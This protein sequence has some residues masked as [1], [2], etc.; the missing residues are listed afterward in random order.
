MKLPLL[1]IAAATTISILQ[2]TNALP[3]FTNTRRIKQVRGLPHI[4]P[5]SH[6]VVEERKGLQEKSPIT[7][8]RRKT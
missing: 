8:S 6:T 3:S 7:Q 1:F 5:K 2:P 4:I